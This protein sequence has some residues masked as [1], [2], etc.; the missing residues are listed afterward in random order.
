M[1]TL[2]EKIAKLNQTLDEYETLSGL[3]RF[4]SSE[5]SDEINSYLTMP[6]KQLEKLHPEDCANISVRL[7]QQAFYIQRLYNRERSQIASMEV[8]LNKRIAQYKNNYSQYLK[9]ELLVASLVNEDEYSKKIQ[10]VIVK[11]SQRTSRLYALADKLNDLSNKFSSLQHAK[12][13]SIKNTRG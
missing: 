4:Q 9:H 8:A 11:A 1:Q 13:T 2:E 3:P 12:I 6:I 5:L 10:D 7:S